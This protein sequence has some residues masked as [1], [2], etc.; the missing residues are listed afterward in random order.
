M[1]HSLQNS[2]SAAFAAIVSAALL[3]GASIAPAINNASSM[4]I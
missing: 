2:V 4:V 1:S 3:V